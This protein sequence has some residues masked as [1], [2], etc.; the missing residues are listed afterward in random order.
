VE[1]ARHDTDSREVGRLGDAFWSPRTPFNPGE[2]SYPVAPCS[3]YAIATHP[4]ANKVTRM[5]TS[6]TA[7]AAWWWCRCACECECMCV[8]VWS[9]S[10]LDA[11]L[12]FHQS[13]KSR[14]KV[15]MKCPPASAHACKHAC[16]PC[17]V[18]CSLNALRVWPLLCDPPAPPH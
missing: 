6:V 13:K 8:C 11:S 5:M 3:A 17:Q 1:H 2:P 12:R 7:G 9:V 16:T 14:R 10:S 4:R 15:T 18:R